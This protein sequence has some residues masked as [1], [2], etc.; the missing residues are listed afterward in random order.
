MPHPQVAVITHLAKPVL[1]LPYFCLSRVATGG[2][3]FSL[4]FFILKAAEVFTKKLYLCL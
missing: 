2:E 4:R 3:G 1:L